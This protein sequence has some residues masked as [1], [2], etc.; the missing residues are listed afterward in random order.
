MINDSVR[1][2]EGGFNFG[3]A[4]LLQLNKDNPTALAAIGATIA[5]SLNEGGTKAANLAAALVATGN[6]SLI[7]GVMVGSGVNRTAQ[8]AISGALAKTLTSVAV[9]SLG[10]ASA[11]ATPEGK[12]AVDL[13]A[14]VSSEVA[15]SGNKNALLS[16]EATG[17]ASLS[18]VAL[19]SSSLVAFA[20]G[21]AQSQQGYVVTLP[22]AAVI[23]AGSAA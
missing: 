23:V 6:V 1:A 5:G 18:T 10:R 21:L 13:A 12:A 2:A 20:Q 4:V 7:A 3:L 8:D 16:L 17:N 19:A 14:K 22:S 9:D 15:V 11:D